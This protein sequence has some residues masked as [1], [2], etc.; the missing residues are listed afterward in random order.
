MIIYKITNTINLKA[1]IGQTIYSLEERWSQH[2]SKSSGCVAIASA[3]L[4]Y[5][6]E[7]FTIEI[8]AI[9]NSLEE[10]NKKESQFIKEQNT[11]SPYGYNLT[12][13]G[14]GKTLTQEVKDK[15]S[16]ANKGR[17]H[18]EAFRQMRKDIQTGKSPSEETKIKM[19]AAA[20]GKSKSDTHRAN[21]SKAK[22]GNKLPEYARQSIRLKLQK[23]IKCDQTNQ[24][25]ASAS[26][27][28]KELKIGKSTIMKILKK[29]KP[30]FKGLSFSYI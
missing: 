9:C 22:M 19:S 18:S 23:P 3:L 27:A 13:G 5:G 14:E 25:F 7:N 24:I 4:K 8:M 16:K 1:Y 15:I 28:A 10:L 20:S 29:R 26:H 6:K 12:S 2:N 30:Y 17:V 11:I 21:I